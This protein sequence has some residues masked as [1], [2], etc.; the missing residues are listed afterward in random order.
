M[1]SISKAS[2]RR[3]LKYSLIG[4]GT[5]LGDLILLYI[6]TDWLHLYYLFAAGLAFLVAVSVNYL[7]SRRV[8]FKGT[9]RGQTAGYV[10]FII[11]AGAGLMFVTGGMYVLVEWLGVYYVWARILVA[12]VT[13]VWNYL[14]NLF[15]NFKVANLEQF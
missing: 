10:Y 1:I 9:K 7:I 11:I 5:F 8:V 2:V 14:M 6:F 12:S 4:F 15:F 3:F 13:G